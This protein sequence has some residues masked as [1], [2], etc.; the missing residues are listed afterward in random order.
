M[1]FRSRTARVAL[2]QA[3]VEV[4]TFFGAR[5][6]E[7]VFTGSGTEA[8]N[9]AVHGALTRTTGRTGAITTAVEHSA[10][11]EAIAARTDAV[12]TIGVDRDGRIDADALVA[13]VR[14]D[15][16]LV[17]VHLANHEVGTIQPVHD[18]ADRLGPDRPLL[19][20]DARAACGHVPVDFAALGADLCS[21]TAHTWGEIGRAHV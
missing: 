13:A 2:E 8:V 4:A 10:V 9:A 14:P 5:P 16:A 11:T 17:S 15:T 1:L 12:T 7:V 19:H 18:L 6:R 21:V 3:R 20:I